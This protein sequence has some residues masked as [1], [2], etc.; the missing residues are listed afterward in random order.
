MNDR[1]RL[2]AIAFDRLKQVYHPC[3]LQGTLLRS[4]RCFFPSGSR[5][6]FKY[7]LTGTLKM[8]YIKMTDLQNCKAWNCRTWNC[9]TWQELVAFC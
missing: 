4:T 5:N 6:R 7:S 2:T 9:K 1:I 3:W 8:T